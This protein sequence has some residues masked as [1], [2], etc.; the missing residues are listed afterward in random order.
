METETK[1]KKFSIWK[2]LSYFIIYSIVGF[3]IE[4]AFGVCTKGVLESRKSFLYGPFCAIYGLGAVTMIYFLQYFKKN[5]YT[6]FFG[7]FLIGSIIEYI[8]SFLGEIIFNIKW[9]DY[10]DKFLNINGRI[11]FTFSLFWGLLAIYLITHFNKLIDKLIDKIKSK[12]SERTLKIIISTISVAIIIDAALTCIGLKVFFTRLI[13][14]NNLDVAF[15]EKYIIKNRE[16]MDSEII[17]KIFS[18]KKML[19]TFPNLKLTASNGD[20]IDV[21]SLLPDIQSYYIKFK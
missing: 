5:N 14:N 21:D 17:N 7:G 4:T 10:S 13:E 15:S 20:T 3:L 2:V 19:R 9:W 8:I 6:L 12:L 16:I 1:I 18:D 11:C